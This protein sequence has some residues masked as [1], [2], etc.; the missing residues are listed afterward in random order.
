MKTKM[1]TKKIIT[2]YSAVGGVGRTMALA[3]MSCLL[4]KE[5]KGKVLMID[6]DMT[7]PALHEYFKPYIPHY[8]RFLIEKEGLIE[9]MQMA[10]KELPEI[11]PDAD[12]EELLDVFFTKILDYIVKVDVP[13]GNDNLY[14]LKAGKF[15][16]DYGDKITNFDWTA[17]FYKRPTFFRHLAFYL[18]KV[19][20]YVLI[21]SKAG[22]HS[23]IGGICTMI[24]PEK[25]VLVFKPQYK[26]SIEMILDL[27]KRAAYYR[28]NHSWDDLRP[29]VIYPLASCVEDTPPNIE[30]RK[31]Y[32]ENFEKNHIGIYGFPE[33]TSMEKYFDEVKI[34][35]VP[36]YSFGERVAV[37]EQDVE[38]S[39]QI[40]YRALLKWFKKSI[41][42]Y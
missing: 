12:E 7:A 28:Q 16:D 36:Q 4:A 13:N 10:D 21:D 30:W 17:F 20:D 14:I 37:L 32:I 1:K 26:R 41:W 39:F 25:L 24:M 11:K 42:E 18:R 19:F 22:T 6:W 33:N 15:D 34:Q 2:F 29:L 9:Y 35:Y 3:N 5:T 27:S 8:E 40:G 38:G 31:K 23:D